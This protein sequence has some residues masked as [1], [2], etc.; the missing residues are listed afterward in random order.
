MISYLTPLCEKAGWN[1]TTSATKG[2]D[3]EA[4]TKGGN[5]TDAAKEDG[6][7]DSGAVGSWKSATFVFAVVFSSVFSSLLI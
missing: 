6:D 4:V 1:K 5:S 2:D 7:K 3:E